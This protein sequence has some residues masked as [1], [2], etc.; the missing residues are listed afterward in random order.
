MNC[1]LLSR[2]LHLRTENKMQQ[3]RQ[4]KYKVPLRSVR[5]TTVAVG[6]QQVL[7]SECLFV[8]LVIPHAMRMLRIILTSETCPDL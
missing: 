1:S 8:P 2:Q 4:G 3:G 7:Y 5:A 6:K